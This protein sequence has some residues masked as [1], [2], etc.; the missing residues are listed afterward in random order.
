MLL[1]KFIVRS[2]IF[3]FIYVEGI[4][5]Y[6]FKFVGFFKLW[7]SFFLFFELCFKNYI[8]ENYVIS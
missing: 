4:W 1:Y 7:C 2:G 6:F 5:V 3:Y 8:D